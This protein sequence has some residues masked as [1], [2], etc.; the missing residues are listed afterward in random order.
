MP[1]IKSVVIVGGGTAGWMAAAAMATRFPNGALSITLVESEELG[2][3]GVGES[4]IPP[5]RDFNHMLG[6]SEAEFIRETKAT[7]KLGIEFKNWGG[8]GEEYIHP[9]G[10]PGH[11]IN[12][13]EFQ[14][15][16][17]RLRAAGDT[18]PIDHY[19]LSAIAAR[20][21]R[22]AAP[23]KNP[24]SILSTFSYAF[25]F[26]AGLYA[27]FL[28]KLAE[29]RQVKRCEGQVNEVIQNPDTGFI[30][31]IKLKTGEVIAGDLFIDC[32]GF[33]GLLINQTLKVDFADWSQ[34]LP[35]D[36]AVA[37]PCAK[38]TVIRP[39]TRAT[40][41]SAGWQWR[42]P[43]QHRTGNGCVYSSEFTSQDEATNILL[44]TLDGEPLAEPRKFSFK[45]GQRV[46]NWSKNCVALGL[47][48]GFLEP[49]ESTSIYLIQYGIQ[50]LLE[51]FPD[52]HFHPVNAREFNRQ[53]NSE[54]ERI[55][56]FIILHYAETRRTDTAFWQRCK[57]MPLPEG[58]RERQD[59]FRASGHVDHSQYGVYAAV[60]I[61][62]GVIPTTFDSR[63][64][65][66]PLEKIQQYL[67][68]I[69][70]QIQAAAENMQSTEDVL[71]A[72]GCVLR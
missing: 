22:F 59:I 11:D 45:A 49:L 28:R 20:L 2:T 70:H 58:L 68:G 16:W 41:H 53:L 61:G 38:T 35:C 5:I 43:L 9:F 63:V 69:K 62:Q 13:I 42:I 48:S 31:S 52:K 46:N 33:K 65:A 6:I 17:L 29:Q 51:L 47:A 12:G 27:A 24:E 55:R 8:L 7:Y 36:S 25:Q 44:K 34:W 15:Y 21:G 72:M 3:V 1:A 14:H 67:A 54:Y 30:E 66:Y 71:R 50:K 19:S 32:T 57:E 4:T 18:T 10:S 37:V 40:A 39:F 26:D 64:A 56:D 23:D 60:C